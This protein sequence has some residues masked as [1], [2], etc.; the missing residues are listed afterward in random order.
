[1]SI[2]NEM[3]AW[4]RPNGNLSPL[5]ASARLRHGVVALA[6]ALALGVVLV[7]LSVPAVWRLT[8]FVPFLFAASGFYQGLYRT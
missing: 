2:F 1:M 5:A 3:E 8:L 7:E 4:A 6:V